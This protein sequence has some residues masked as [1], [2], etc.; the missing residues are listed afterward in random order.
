MDYDL[1]R[2]LDDR[3]YHRIR[4]NWEREFKELDYWEQLLDDYVPETSK[5]DISQIKRGILY[6][7]EKLRRTDEE[8]WNL[9]ITLKIIN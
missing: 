3:V 9:L 1:A 5:L 7:K 8:L 2:I 4:R 6:R